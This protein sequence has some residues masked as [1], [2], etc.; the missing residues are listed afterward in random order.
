MIKQERSLR[1]DISGSEMMIDRK[2]EN[3]RQ[4]SCSM[5]SMVMCEAM[6]GC[7]ERKGGKR[8]A[9]RLCNFAL[10]VMEAKR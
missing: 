3:E 10:T 2:V 4:S 1:F 7:A 6:F 9:A 5:T 8:I